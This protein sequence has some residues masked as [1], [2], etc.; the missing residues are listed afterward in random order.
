MRRH[1]KFFLEDM[2]ESAQNIVEYVGHSAGESFFADKMRVD[3]AVRNFEIIGEAAA[4]V[5]FEIR[6]KYPAIDWRK[7]TDFRNVLIHEYFGVSREIIW[8]AIKNKLPALIDQLK[9]AVAQ[10]S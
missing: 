4:H 8:D 7:I 10:E 9:Y 5:P 3:A 2:L 1:Y 6:N